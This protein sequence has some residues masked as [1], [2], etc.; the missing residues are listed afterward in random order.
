MYKYMKIKDLKKILNEFGTDK[1]N[2]Y[3]MTSADDEGNN[4]RTIGMYIT[5]CNVQEPGQYLDVDF[6]SS[7]PNAVVIG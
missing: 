4:Y 2:D 7:K 6:E 5:E 3:V 1:D